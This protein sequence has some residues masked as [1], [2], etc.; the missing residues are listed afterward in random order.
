MTWYC[1]EERT[2]PI[3][4]FG[5]IQRK[6]LFDKVYSDRE[7]LFMQKQNASPQVILINTKLVPFESGGSLMN[8]IVDNCR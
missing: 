8:S 1:V 4:N 3:S 2:G 6:V 7:A 5:R